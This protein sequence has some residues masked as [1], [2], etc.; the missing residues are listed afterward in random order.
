MGTRTSSPDHTQMA[1]P[2][3]P[4]LAL[5]LGAILATT[6]FRVRLGQGLPLWLDE[7]WTG[8]IV[9]QPDWTSF[10]REAWLDCNP[11]FYYAV[12][13]VWTSF[14]GASDLALRLPSLI[15]MA[16]AALLPLLVQ[17]PALSH[18]A[19]L[20]WALLLCL[21]A[22]GMEIALDARGYGLLFFLSVAQAIAFLHLMATPTRPAA[23]R[24]ALL[25]S[26]AGLTHYH[27]L[28]I[29]GLQGL[30]LLACHKK[31]ALRLWPA[32]LA[33][34]P[35]FGWLA[36]HAPRLADYARPDVAWY[37]P[38]T[39]S[40][41]GNF[42]RYAFG[43]VNWIWVGGAALLIVAA[44]FSGRGSTPAR[45][46]RI[47]CITLII[48][49][50]LALGI[51][52]LLGSMRPMLTDRYLVP[53]VPAVLLG[54][55]CAVRADAAWGTSRG[56]GLVLL[57]VLSIDAAALRTQLEAKTSYGFAKAS[58]HVAQSGATHLVFSWDHPSSPILA[59]ASLAK[60]GS[61][62]LERAGRPLPTKIVQLRPGEDG[63]ARLAAIAGPDGAVIWIYNRARDSAARKRPPRLDAWPTRSCRWYRGAWI[64]TLACGPVRTISPP[65][66]K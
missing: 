49:G 66:A 30:A 63:N 26:L 36:I 6:A 44:L 33:F 4:T 46:E 12:M 27:A 19:R 10:W 31:T 40:L 3:W 53:L 52:L 15:F 38:L 58:A 8:M 48:C 21:W 20:I 64:G 39:A 43:I 2:P 57:Y 32:A 25:A 50:I 23:W 56:F 1:R 62:F 5:G 37:E 35:A 17:V 45:A 28:L 16:L 65:I 61:F 59:P 51:E 42:I 18:R 41:A 34:V 55:T 24:W 47:A 9:T 60:L 13:A 11:P 7:T 29:G 22:P 14:F 54:L